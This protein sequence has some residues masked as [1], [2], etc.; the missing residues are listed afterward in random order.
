MSIKQ[1]K[2]NDKR[3]SGLQPG[4]A[5]GDDLLQGRL[6]LHGDGGLA[7]GAAK[8]GFPLGGR[9]SHHPAN[10]GGFQAEH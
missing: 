8:D 10:R 4:F 2:T 6:L 1:S 5:P 7:A 9:G 3:F